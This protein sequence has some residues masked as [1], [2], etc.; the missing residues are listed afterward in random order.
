MK[1]AEDAAFAAAS[2]SFAGPQATSISGQAARRIDGPHIDNTTLL[3]N[4]QLPVEITGRAGV[5]GHQFDLPT[6]FP[7]G[8]VA[9]NAVL[10]RK[11]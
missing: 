3:A 5:T 11:R 10:L 8:A 1:T 7:V 9:H 6:D 4:L 2:S